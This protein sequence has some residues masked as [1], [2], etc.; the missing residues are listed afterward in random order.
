MLPSKQVTVTE[1]PSYEGCKK[2]KNYVNKHD[3]IETKFNINTYYHY[4]ILQTFTSKCKMDHC[5]AFSNV[6]ALNLG[7]F[8]MIFFVLQ[9]RFVCRKPSQLTRLTFEN[10]FFYQLWF[11]QLGEVTDLRFQNMR[12][13]RASFHQAN[14]NCLPS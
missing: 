3:K 12:F 6:M 9:F 11:T 2:L 4:Q 1:N 14:F 5:N 13:L 8:K 10:C 7:S